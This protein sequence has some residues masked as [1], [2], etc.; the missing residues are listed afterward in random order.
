VPLGTSRVKWLHLEVRACGFYLK[1]NSDLFD[2]RF[3]KLT[4]SQIPEQDG[5]RENLP[6]FDFFRRC[7]FFGHGIFHR[8][9]PVIFLRV[10]N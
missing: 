7:N 8:S 9:T 10:G 5:R 1:I 6:A 2:S 4:T 3:V